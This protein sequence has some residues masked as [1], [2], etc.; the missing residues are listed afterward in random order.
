MVVVIRR[1]VYEVQLSRA[2]GTPVLAGAHLPVW[3]GAV[4][5]DDRDTAAA[6]LLAHAGAIEAAGLVGRVVERSLYREEEWA[7]KVPWV[8]T[9]PEQE[10]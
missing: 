7:D 10:S 2:D 6:A 9:K 8:I 1:V 3:T 4:L 5:F